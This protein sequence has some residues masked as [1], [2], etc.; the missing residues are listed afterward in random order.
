MNFTVRNDISAAYLMGKLAFDVAGVPVHGNMGVHYEQT[1][2][3]I[4]ALNKQIDSSGNITYVPEQFRQKY[5]RPP[6]VGAAGRQ[7]CATT[8]C[9]A[10]P[11]TRP[12]FGRRRAT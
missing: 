4:N 8:W 12:S 6:A 9:C 5:Q 7:T 3:L 2:E 11:T 10:L 1:D